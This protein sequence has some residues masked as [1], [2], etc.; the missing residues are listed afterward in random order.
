MQEWIFIRK[1]KKD[2]RIVE[3]FKGIIVREIKKKEKGREK[4]TE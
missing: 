3:F 4:L 1:K 2:I